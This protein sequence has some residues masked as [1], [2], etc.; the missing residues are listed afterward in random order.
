MHEGEKNKKQASEGG[1]LCMPKKYLFTYD[2]GTSDYEPCSESDTTKS[3]S[4]EKFTSFS[5]TLFQHLRYQ[6][7]ILI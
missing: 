3:I 7:Q 2:S 6:P 5:S 1:G 4:S